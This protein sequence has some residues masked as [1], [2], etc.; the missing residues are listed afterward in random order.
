LGLLEEA[1]G[2]S[3]LPAVLLK[4]IWFLDDEFDGSTELPVVW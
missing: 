3:P 1:V 4:I 2:N